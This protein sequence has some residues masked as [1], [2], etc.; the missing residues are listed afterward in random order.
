[1]TAEISILNKTAIALAADSAVTIENSKDRKIFNT[2]NKLFMLSKYHPIGI[3]IYGNADINGMPWENII[4]YYRKDLRD[5]KLDTIEEYANSFFLFLQNN[6]KSLIPQEEQI[7]FFEY[8]TFSLFTHLKNEIDKKVDQYFKVHN[9]IN[10]LVLKRISASIVNENY[11]IWNNS[12]TL[13]HLPKNFSKLI[14]NKHKKLI[15]ELKKNIFQNLP[16]SKLTDLRLNK[17]ASL[18]FVKDI[19]SDSYSGLVIAGYGEKEFFPG[20]IAYKIEGI[21]EDNIKYKIEKSKKINFDNTAMI[22]PFAQSEMVATFME[23]IHPFYNNF[24]NGYLGKIL[25]SEFPESVAK[26]VAGNKKTKDALARKIGKVGKNVLKVFNK[27]LEEFKIRKHISPILDVVA[28]LPKDELAS[29]AESF[30]NLT[31]LKR[32]VTMVSETVGGPI[33]VAV[34]SKGDGF[35]WIKRKH[36]FDPKV[37]PGFFANYYL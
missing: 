36:Y 11:K 8:S 1:M 30:V 22:V 6:I 20:L 24:L 21:F 27:E 37:N 19:F 34:I 10:D 31:S 32:R 16:F 9:S 7:E 15:E 4:K 33:D 29:M 17:I 5:K 14:L 23:G 28:V 25:E 18:I 3:M 12:D 26:A 2:V 13:N 35:I